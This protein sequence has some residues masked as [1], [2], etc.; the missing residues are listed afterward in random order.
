S[1]ISEMSSGASAY[2][3]SYLLPKAIEFC[4]EVKSLGGSLLSALEKRDA[5]QM[6]LLRGTHEISLLNAVR[7]IKKKNIEEANSSIL[8]LNES[9]KS[10]Q[11]KIDE[12]GKRIDNNISALESTQMGMTIGSLGL[13]YVATGTHALSVA[14][15][16]LPEFLMGIAGAFGSPVAQMNLKPSKAV[17]KAA[18]TM[19]SLAHALD[20]VASI[21][22]TYASWERRKQDWQ[23]Q[24]DLA[25][26]EHEQITQQRNGAYIRQSSAIIDLENHEKQIEQAQKVRDLMEGKYTNQQL[27]N[28]M[29]TQLS[30][31]YFQSYQLAF[32]LARKAEKA[33]AYEMGVDQPEII[34]F[35]YWDSLKKGLMSG[36][37]LQLDLRRLEMAYMEQNKR[38]FELTKH[39]SMALFNSSALLD[40]KE[41][42]VCEF[43]IPEILFDLDH[44][45]HYMRRIRSV[46][47]TIPCITGPYSGVH[48]QLT[49]LSSKVRKLAD[50][51]D[52]YIE[53]ANDKRFAYEFTDIQSIATS[54]GQND[55]GVFELNFRD[56][57]YLPFERRGAISR[58]KL[59]LPGTFRQFNYDSISD[60]IIHLNYT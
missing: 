39:I 44:P 57:R 32:D 15:A 29:V 59:E 47:L 13:K 21:I 40:L 12:Y 37:K 60:I 14:T 58:W 31:V 3:F 35:G 11:T 33:F 8:S 53:V 19:E 34:E 16:S 55:S 51:D 18:L 25:D 2:R 26:I 27:Y 23:L 6:A 9:L 1:A 24:K 10:A 22:G 30:T 42:G 52:G 54:S 56:E 20:S 4:N 36:E 45:S 5:E 48:A 41:K 38:E 50:V 28:W 49:L 17:S 43:Q 46:S 7:E